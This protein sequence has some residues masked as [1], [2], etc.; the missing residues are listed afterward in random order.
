MSQHNEKHEITVV[1]IDLGKTW[2]QVCGQDGSGRVGLARK[3]KPKAL[4]AL[5]SLGQDSTGVWARGQADRP[6][7]RQAVREDEQERPC[8]CRGHLRSGAASFDAVCRYQ[9]GGATGPA[10]PA[11]DPQPGGGDSAN[12]GILLRR[13]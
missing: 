4:R 9:D 6:A 2:V 12:R 1:G 8:R 11:P 5:A 13:F 10:G 3:M 7:V